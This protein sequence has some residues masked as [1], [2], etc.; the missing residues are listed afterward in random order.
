MEL[1]LTIPRNRVES[2]VRL[3]PVKLMAA[4][5]ARALSAAAFARVAGVSVGTLSAVLHHGTPV[6]PRIARRIA[7]GLRDN[8]VV[9]GL[10]ELLAEAESLPSEAAA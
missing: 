4:L 10:S 7:A 9:Q 2:H 1:A 6:T 8:Q 3:D 5:N